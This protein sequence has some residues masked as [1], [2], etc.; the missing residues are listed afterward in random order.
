MV[1][2]KCDWSP[3]LLSLLTCLCEISGNYVTMILEL[4]ACF[5]TLALWSSGLRL[6]TC[7]ILAVS[8]SYK[9]SSSSL[10]CL[11]LISCFILLKAA[12]S[13]LSLYFSYSILAR[14]ACSSWCSFL[15]ISAIC[16][17]WASIASPWVNGKKL[18]LSFMF[19]SFSPT[20]FCNLSTKI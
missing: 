19:S 6:A 17:L 14:F 10:S 7:Y 11:S 12:W 13:S 18:I 8:T 9:Y 16:L 15:W 20:C 4:S 1:L 5:R 3:I 2:E